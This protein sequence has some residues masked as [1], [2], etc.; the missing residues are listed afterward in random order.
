MGARTAS[1]ACEEFVTYFGAFGRSS[2]NPGV[3]TCCS[4]EE[5]DDN[6]SSVDDIL[7]TSRG[8][9]SFR[10]GNDQLLTGT[11]HVGRAADIP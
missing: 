2:K 7:G 4:I 1:R 11:T 9:E 10:L 3:L 5:Y 8:V 6:R